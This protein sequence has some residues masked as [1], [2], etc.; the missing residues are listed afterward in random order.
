MTKIRSLYVQLEP[1][2]KMAQ[3]LKEGQVVATEKVDS[4]A[5]QM[6]DIMRKL[7]VG[8]NYDIETYIEQL[9]VQ[10]TSKPSLTTSTDF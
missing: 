2:K 3:Q 10:M 5:R 1:M 8:I 6:E 4:L 9:H 7:Q